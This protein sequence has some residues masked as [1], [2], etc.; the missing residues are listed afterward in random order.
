MAQLIMRL[1]RPGWGCVVA[2]FI[3][4]AQ[5]YGCRRQ[6]ARSRSGD[7]MQRCCAMVG[8]SPLDAG[9]TASDCHGSKAGLVGD[10]I[11]H[12]TGVRPA[13]GCV[14]KSRDGL[15]LMNHG[16]SPRRHICRATV[17]HRPPRAWPA[18]A[19]R[20]KGI[21]G[22]APGG[23]AGRRS[24]VWSPPAG[25]GG[26]LP[27]PAACKTGLRAGGAVAG[28]EVS[29][30]G[31]GPHVRSPVAGAAAPEIR[32]YR[33]GPAGHD[34][35]RATSWACSDDSVGISPGRRAPPQGAAPARER[36]IEIEKKRMGSCQWGAAACARNHNRTLQCRRSHQDSGLVN[37]QGLRP[38]ATGVAQMAGRT[39]ETKRL[40]APLIKQPFCP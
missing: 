11:A 36:A 32:R 29:K 21:Q 6:P 23:S 7:V 40:R 22:G 33:P 24:R 5:R 30:G 2:V 25:R 14:M 31:I 3:V 19:C 34:G 26:A 20:G 1:T 39:L 28:T 18:P 9:T 13:R 27:G 4:R 38:V 16:V 8:P 17:P 12:K 10:V 35:Q 15:A 37:A